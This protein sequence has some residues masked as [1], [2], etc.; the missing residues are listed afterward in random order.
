VADFLAV[1]DFLP[2][3][4]GLPCDR[5]QVVPLLDG[6]VMYR[7]CDLERP[8]VVI[9]LVAVRLVRPVQLVAH[10]LDV[11]VEYRRCDLERRLVVVRLVQLVGGFV[12]PAETF[13]IKELHCVQG[14]RDAIS[15]TIFP[16]LSWCPEIIIPIESL[17]FDTL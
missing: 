3:V 5:Q 2:V 17:Q 10:L 6:E 14:T 13:A 15:L 12:H 4:A 11:E 1:A 7:R 9:R 16:H 8:L